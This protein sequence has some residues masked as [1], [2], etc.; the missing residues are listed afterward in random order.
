M[1]RERPFFILSPVGIACYLVRVFNT[2]NLPV[3]YSCKSVLS[4][5]RYIKLALGTTEQPKAIHI[6]IAN[7][8]STRSN[9]I[10]TYDILCSIKR[11]GSAGVRPITY[12]R[13]LKILSSEFGHRLPPLCRC[14]LNYQKQHT[15]A[16]Q[17]N[18]K[19][20]LWTSSRKAKLYIAS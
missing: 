8:D 5:S 10:Y 4:S 2:W 3:E 16:L 18:K 17:K 20:R 14:L 6:R 15:I 12:I 7:H 19:N 9:S 1:F 13:L 11:N